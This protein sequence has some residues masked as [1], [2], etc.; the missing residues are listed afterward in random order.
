MQ[1]REGETRGFRVVKGRERGVTEE[2]LLLSESGQDGHIR[3]G[4]RRSQRH[5]AGA[6]P[7]SRKQTRVTEPGCSFVLEL[8]GTLGVRIRLVRQLHWPQGCPDRQPHFV[9]GM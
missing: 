3:S 8:E 2:R 7:C 9:S 6:R 1:G 5:Q 4:M